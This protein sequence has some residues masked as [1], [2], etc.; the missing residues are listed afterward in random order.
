M[1]RTGPLKP[2]TEGECTVWFYFYLVAKSRKWGIIRFL[3]G[4][5]DTTV[6]EPEV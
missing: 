6:V 4:G 3:G 2:G 1:I 5:G